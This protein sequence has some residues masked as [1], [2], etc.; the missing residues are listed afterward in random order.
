[1]AS[2]SA[3]MR[4]L[5]SAVKVRRRGRAAGSSATPTSWARSNRDALVMV[6]VL[7]VPVSPCRDGH[8]QRMSHLSLTDRDGHSDPPVVRHLLTGMRCENHDVEIGVHPS[9]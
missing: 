6:I 1:M 5:Y 9:G 3:R 2:Y 4:A 8:L 7:D